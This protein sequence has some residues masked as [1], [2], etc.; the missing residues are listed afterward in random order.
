MIAVYLSVLIVLAL[1]HGL[2]RLRVRR[3]ERRFTAVAAAA[4]ALLKQTSYRSGNG[5]PDPYAVAK[6]QFELARLAMRRDR[7]EDRYTSWQGFAER[8]GR[9]RRRLFG[10]RGKVLPYVFGALDVAA[11][12][13]VMDL[14]GIGVTQLKAMVGM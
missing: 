7:L 1:L 3:L 10:Y 11:A 4:D 8:F 13:A 5:R 2:V 12:M 14:Y 6:N 9:L